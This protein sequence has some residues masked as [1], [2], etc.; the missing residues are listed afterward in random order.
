VEL[1]IR[2]VT[3]PGPG[4][5]LRVVVY[6]IVIVIVAA[7]V[8]WA[9]QELV[10]M[11]SL[12]AGAGLAGGQTAL[13]RVERGPAAQPAGEPEPPSRELLWQPGFSGPFRPGPQT[14]GR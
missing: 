7:L 2:V 10:T 11:V 3:R 4:I 6:V 8:V 13:V 9:G 12:I 14:G 5:K 1:S